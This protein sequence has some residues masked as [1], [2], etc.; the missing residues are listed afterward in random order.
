MGENAESCGGE[1]TCVTELLER[2][3]FLG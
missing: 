2:L 3:F 1:Q